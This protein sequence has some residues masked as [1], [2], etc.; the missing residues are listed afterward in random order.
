MHTN[1]YKKLLRSYQVRIANTYQSKL[2][3][4]MGNINFV[5]ALDLRKI[6]DKKTKR[7]K[8]HYIFFTSTLVISNILIDTN[9]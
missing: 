1:R 3:T 2:I 9:M 7:K 5:K 8:Q 6:R 4:Q